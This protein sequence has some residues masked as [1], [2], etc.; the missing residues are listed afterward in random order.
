MVTEN[1]NKKKGKSMKYF[2]FLNIMGF[3]WFVCVGVLIYSGITGEIDYGLVIE[4]F[5][6]LLKEL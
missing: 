2:N 3:V 6:E 5:I 4:Q 1:K